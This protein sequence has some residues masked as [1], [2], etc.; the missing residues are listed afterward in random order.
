PRGTVEKKHKSVWGGIV[1]A[2][3]FSQLGYS[4]Q[5]NRRVFLGCQILLDLSFKVVSQ[6]VVRKP[7]HK[8]HTK[9][10]GVKAELL[11]RRM[12][13]AKGKCQEQIAKSHR[14]FSLRDFT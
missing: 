14:L 5:N 8:K 7:F 9:K 6:H 1:G 13:G 12:K 11:Y 2:S 4:E 3:Q 10:Y